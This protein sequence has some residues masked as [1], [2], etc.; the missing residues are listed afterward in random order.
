MSIFLGTTQISARELW[1]TNINLAYFGSTVIYGTAPVVPSNGLLGW[2]VSYYKCDTDWTFTDSHWSN[3][4]TINWATFNATWKIN[5]DYSYITN[6]Y[7]TIDW[8]RTSL[9]TTTTWTW[10]FWFKPDDA[11]PSGSQALISFWDTNAWN[12]ITLE[13]VASSGALRGV[14]TSWGS[15]KW[16]ITT[17][18]WHGSTSVYSNV[19]IT[20]NGTEPN[21][22][23]DGVDVGATFPTTTDKTVWFN[24]LSLLDNWRISCRN[25]NS[26]WNATFFNWD[27][28]EVGFWSSV[29]SASD[30]TALYNG[31]AWLSYDDFTT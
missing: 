15:N 11:T 28:D 24:D 31:W 18:G 27:I 2:L 5:W 10:S 26:W 12:R 20:Q 30:I 29:L 9:A 21:I 17:S 16:N 1:T 3:T 23:V 19:I 14:A 25:F 22:Y 8:V 7:I 6:D 4:G 13:H